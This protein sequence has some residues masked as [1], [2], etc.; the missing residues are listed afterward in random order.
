MSLHYF[1][2]L[3]LIAFSVCSSKFQTGVQVFVDIKLDLRL[4]FASSFGQE[5]A[6]EHFLVI[7]VQCNFY[8]L[9]LK[10]IFE[11]FNFGSYSGV[12]VLDF[13]R[14]ELRLILIKCSKELSILF[15]GLT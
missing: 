13:S 11:H 10:V 14:V 6:L 7:D 8:E 2:N 3:L 1:E 4:L 5:V 12:D 9:L 15:V